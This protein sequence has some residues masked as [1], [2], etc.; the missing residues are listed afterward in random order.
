M[1]IRL[2]GWVSDKNFFIRSISGNK[3]TFCFGLTKWK[4]IYVMFKNAK[5]KNVKA[6]SAFSSS[7]S[8]IYNFRYG[9]KKVKYQTERKL[10]HKKVGIP[11]SCTM[12]L[13]VLFQKY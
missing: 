7:S 2:C 5:G 8:I 6:F 10:W 13:K 12:Q 9:K 4:I 3:T 11:V 1:H